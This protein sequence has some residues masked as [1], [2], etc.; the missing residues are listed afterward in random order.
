[1][2]DNIFESATQMPTFEFNK[3]VTG[4]FDDMINRSVPFYTQ[5]LKQVAHWLAHKPISTIWG[6]PRGP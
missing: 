5:I 2:R 1:M 3:T 4:V 6:A